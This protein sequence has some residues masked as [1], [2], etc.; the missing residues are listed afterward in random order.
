MRDEPYHRW[1][2]HDLLGRSRNVDGSQ[3]RI[4]MSGLAYEGGQTMRKEVHHI[5]ETSLAPETIECINGSMSSSTNLTMGSP[6]CV[7]RVRGTKPLAVPNTSIHVPLIDSFTVVE[8]RN[9]EGNRC[10]YIWLD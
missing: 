8:P 6:Y 5:K 3:W 4:V 2:L 10:K 7:I 9:L 1:F